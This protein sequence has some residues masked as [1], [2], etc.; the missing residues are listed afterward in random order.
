MDQTYFLCRQLTIDS[1]KINLSLHAMLRL[2]LSCHSAPL[3]FTSFKLINTENEYLNNVEHYHHQQHDS[4]ILS[5]SLIYWNSVKYL[6]TMHYIT[7]MLFR[8]GWL[9]GSLDL[10]GNVTG[11]LYSLINGLN[12]LIHLRSS[13]EDDEN[14]DGENVTMINL[15]D[16]NLFVCQQNIDFSSSTVAM[17]IGTVASDSTTFSLK[18][19]RNVGFIYRLT[20]GLSSLTRRTTGGLL[21]SISGIASSLARNLDYLSLDPHY[22]QHQD[23]IRRHHTPKGFSEG[24]QQGLSSLGLCLLS[25]IAGVAD[26]PLQAIFKTMDNTI[27][28]SDSIFNSSVDS[29]STPNF[30]LSTLGGFGRGL[31]GVVTK[32]VAGA[33]ELIAQTSKGLLH[34]TN[35][36][37]EIIIPSKYGEPYISSEIGL[38]LQYQNVDVM[39]L[40]YWGSV[41]LRYVQSNVSNSNYHD[42]EE[43]SICSWFTTGIYNHNNENYSIAQSH[44]VN[45]TLLW[46][47]ASLDPNIV[48]ASVITNEINNSY[49]SWFEQFPNEVLRRFIDT[50]IGFDSKFV[51]IIDTSVNDNFH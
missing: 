3:H 16:K 6:L 41:A 42:N 44:I 25:A 28:Y 11:L 23:H 36:S 29:Q 47:S 38:R 48:Y 31:V 7:Q 34:G 40:R 37:A 22:E 17:S 35:N 10:L 50:I 8:S 1:F 12:D 39:I 18:Y 45:D 24:I 13:N 26:Q 27:V 4:N 15:S 14:N 32:P 43:L 9:V 51:E 30:L 46:I 20:Q 33:A 5:G 19:N 21:L 2:Y 49:F